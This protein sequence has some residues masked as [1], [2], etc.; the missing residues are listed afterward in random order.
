MKFLSKRETFEDLNF[1]TYKFILQINLFSMFTNWLMKNS[2]SHYFRKYFGFF[3]VDIDFGCYMLT[4]ETQLVV[5]TFVVREVLFWRHVVKRNCLKKDCQRFQ[6]KQNK[7]LTWSVLL[8]SLRKLFFFVQNCCLTFIQKI[9]NLI[10]T[11]HLRY[12]NIA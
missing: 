11:Y 4:V 1:V 10:I 7:L 3:D 9:S 5:Q 12:N 2:L 8:W 6:F